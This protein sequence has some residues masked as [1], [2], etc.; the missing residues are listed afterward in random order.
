MPL[1]M[2]EAVI[3]AAT[4]PSQI[5]VPGMHGQKPAST[6]QDRYT[7]ITPN[8]VTCPVTGLN[9]PRLFQLLAGPARAHVRV[10]SLKQ[11]GQIRAKR[12]FHVGDML[13]YLNNLA[14]SQQDETA[15]KAQEVAA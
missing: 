7:P 5:A 3:H 10:V 2:R 12:L 15:D 8:G 14:A 6:S 1:R 4:M 9:H 13:A 11:P